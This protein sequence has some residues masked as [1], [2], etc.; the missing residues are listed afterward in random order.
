M[1]VSSIYAAAGLAQAAYA[2][3]LESGDTGTALSTKL[4]VPQMLEKGMTASQADRTSLQYLVIH[5]ETYL[6]SGFSATLFRDVR[7]NEY[8]FALRGSARFSVSEPDWLDANIDN[9][10]NGVSRDQ[11]V[12]MV[13]LYIRLTSSSNAIVSQYRYDFYS[14]SVVVASSASGLGL[15]S[16]S[17]TLTITGHSLGGHLAT[18]FALLFPS[19]AVDAYTFNS[20]GFIGWSRDLFNQL[21]ELLRT[22]VT[23]VSITPVTSPINPI[24]DITAPLD[25][26]SH[27][28]EAHLG[29]PMEV[30]VES[31]DEL[32]IIENHGIDRLVDALAVINFM[33]ELDDRLTIERANQIIESASDTMHDSLDLVMSG[34]A[35]LFGLSG[36]SFDAGNDAVYELIEM[37]SEQLGGAEF[38]IEPLSGTDI[39][40]YAL[41]DTE[42]GRGYRFALVN[43]LPFAITSNL[44]E[45]TANSAEYDLDNFSSD[46]LTDRAMLLSAIAQRNAVDGE[47]PAQILGNA[48]RF[49][50]VEIGEFFAGA[51]SSGQGGSNT[52]DPDD[53]TN[54][55]FGNDEA[56]SIHGLSQD[57]RLY[58]MAGD[59][60]IDGNSGSDL[61]EGGA[62]NDVMQGGIGTDYLF[63]GTGDD[64]YIYADGDGLDFISDTS[65]DNRLQVNGVILSGSLATFT[66]LAPGIDTYVAFDGLGEVI[67]NAPY[68]RKV[69]AGLI[70]H[71]NDGQGGLIVINDWDAVSNNFGITLSENTDSIDVTA[72]LAP[73]GIGVTETS[74]PDPNNT[75]QTLYQLVGGSGSDLIVGNDRRE[76]L[77]G[78]AGPDLLFGGGGTD[79]VS[80]G[81]GDDV[82]YANIQSDLDNIRQA[83]EG[84]IVATRDFLSGGDGDDVLVGSAGIE[85]GLAGGAGNDT[86]Y[87][88]KGVDHIFG[89]HDW[90]AS[91]HAW[92]VTVT[93]VNDNGFEY[94]NFVYSAN[95]ASSSEPPGDDTIYAGDG[96]DRVWAG[97][98]DDVV[99]GGAGAD[100]LTGDAGND[101][102]F[103]G[104]GDDSL[105]GDNFDTRLGTQYGY[106][107]DFLDGGEG[108][109]TLRGN[110]GDDYLV[111]GAG[112]DELYGDM[113]ALAGELHGNDTLYGGAGA[114]NL[115]GQGGRDLLFGGDDDDFLWGDSEQVSGQFHDADILFGGNGHDELVGGGGSDLL[116]GNAGDDLLIGDSSYLDAMYHGAD[117]L[118]GGDGNDQVSGNGGDDKIFGEQG[119]DNLWGNAGNDIIFGGDGDDDLSGNEGD[120]VL[121]GG[122]GSDR[123]FA[124][125]GND[126]LIGDSGDDILYGGT[127]YDQYFVSGFESDLI[128]DEDDNYSV[129]T[130]LNLSDIEHLRVTE[131]ST[132]LS[133]SNGQ[134]LTFSDTLFEDGKLHL[135]TG[136][137]FDR[138]NIEQDITLSA[139]GRTYIAGTQN[140][141]V[142][143]GSGADHIL[144]AEGMDFLYGNGGADTLEGG[145]QDDI[146]WGDTGNDTLL[147]GEGR[148]ILWGGEGDDFLAGGSDIDT[149]VGG[150]GSDTYSVW[151]NEGADVIDNTDTSGGFD[152]LYIHGQL[153]PVAD[154]F[155]RDGDDLLIDTGVDV[156]TVLNQFREYG[157]DNNRFYALDNIYFSSTGTS[158]TA[159]DIANEVGMPQ[160]FGESFSI[161]VGQPWVVTFDELL[162]NDFLGDPGPVTITA[163]GNSYN[164]IA[165]LNP[166]DQTIT[167][168]SAQNLA[169]EAVFDYTV[170]NGISSFSA[171][172]SLQL[173]NAPPEVSSDSLSTML[174]QSRVISFA[175]LLANDR[176]ADG[177]ELDIIAIG[178]V[179]HGQIEFDRPNRFITF[180]PEPGY[181]GT[182][183]F[184]FTVTDGYERVDTSAYVYVSGPNVAPAAAPDQMIIGKNQPY[185][186]S[187]AEL[188]ENDRDANEDVL[189]ITAVSPSAHGSVVLD[190]TEETITFTPSADYVGLATFELTVSDGALHVNS[191]VSID[192]RDSPVLLGTLANDSLRIEP[193]RHLDEY[194]VYGLEGNDDIR[195]YGGDKVIYGGAGDDSIT[196]LQYAP[197]IYGGLGNDV[198][199]GSLGATIYGGSGD[200]IIHS[201][202]HVT[203][204]P[205][206]DI[207]YGDPL[208]ANTYYYNQGD[209]QDRIVE[210]FG[211]GAYYGVNRLVFGAGITMPGSMSSDGTEARFNNVDIVFDGLKPFEFTFELADGS[212]RSAGDISSFVRVERDTPTS[213]GGG[214]G[215]DTVIVNSIC[216]DR[217]SGGAGDDYLVAM[218]GHDTVLGG[219]GNDIIEIIGQYG[220]GHRFYGEGGDDVY[221]LGSGSIA[222]AH[223]ISTYDHT[224]IYQ[225]DAGDDRL[226]INSDLIKPWNLSLSKVG[227]DLNL[228]Y[229]LLSLTI[230]N[231]FL[232]YGEDDNRKLALDRIEFGALEKETSYAEGNPSI[233]WDKIDTAA[234]SPTVVWNQQYIAE[235]VGLTWAG[236]SEVVAVDDFLVA[237]QNSSFVM[238]FSDL[239]A[240]D[241]D[242]DNDS[243]TIESVAN[244]KNGTVS[245]DSV[246]RIITFAP[247][248]D[249]QG[250]ARFEYTVNDGFYTDKGIVFLSV[251]GP[252]APEETF[253]YRGN[254]IRKHEGGGTFSYAAFDSADRQVF[255][256]DA[257]GTVTEVRYDTQNRVTDRIV[258]RTSVSEYLAAWLVDNPSEVAPSASD[259]SAFFAKIH[260]EG[261]L[262]FRQLLANSDANYEMDSEQWSGDNWARVAESGDL[263]FKGVVAIGTIASTAL[264]QTINLSG[265]DTAVIDSA[266]GALELTIGGSHLSPADLQASW[267][268]TFYD[269]NPADG[270]LQLGSPFV[271][272]ST[273]DDEWRTEEFQ[274]GVPVGARYAALV[275]SAT[276]P[277][278]S[279]G[280]PVAVANDRPVYFDDLRVEAHLAGEAGDFVPEADMAAH[281]QFN[282]EVTA[283]DLASLEIETAKL[284]E[285]DFE[286][287]LVTAAD[288][289]PGV[290]VSLDGE[291]IHFFPAENFVGRPG[292]QVSIDDSGVS[293]TAA[294]DVDVQLI[295]G[296]D[297]VQLVD[298]L[299]GTAAADLL[300]GFAGDDT[301]RGHDGDDILVG[302]PG[303]DSLTGGEGSDTYRF[304]RGDGS[305]VI[306]NGAADNLSTTDTL[307]I[308][309]DLSVVT[310]ARTGASLDLILSLAGG[311]ALRLTDYF[312]D[313]AVDLIQFDSGEVWRP[314][315]AKAIVLTG[316]TGNDT[317]Y[318]FAG[319]DVLIGNGGSDVLYGSYLGGNDTLFGGQGDDTLIGCN[320]GENA[321][322]GESG[323]DLLLSFGAGADTLDGGVGNDTLGAGYGGIDTLIGGQGSDTY[324]YAGE[325][326]EKVI[327]NYSS[328]WAA[329]DDVLNFQRESSGEEVWFS[330]AGDDLLVEFVGR[331]G[332]AVLMNWYQA[333][334]SLINPYAYMDEMHAGSE[335]LSIRNAQDIV[336]F[337]VLVQ[338]M[339]DFGDRSTIVGD[340]GVLPV[341]NP[342]L[343]NSLAAAQSSAWD[344]ALT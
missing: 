322:Y 116:Y 194:L 186:F 19:V 62:G 46:Y 33:S 218:G 147:G 224:N 340:G 5:Q 117:T 154:R 173:T 318:D 330:R 30:S 238:T 146:L 209:G 28:G 155:S 184:E 9:A 101:S 128:Y 204:G 149:L 242:L 269:A 40:T 159:V 240:N 231:H 76:Q 308:D 57:D 291:M 157:T 341:D 121:S 261:G 169:A 223:V 222:G 274:I 337:D 207:L 284:V 43:L 201:G 324:V 178:P 35:K 175:E 129:Y 262:H 227:Y 309:A 13:N 60:T 71:L 123:L 59:D 61:L 165:T 326:G 131:T 301:L 210:I 64:T 343:L 137:A 338:A 245:I 141:I 303:S 52:V 106:G 140:D 42:A 321:L 300:F 81:T 80:G 170:S 86:I 2:E 212:V 45:T 107:D 285:S 55:V 319:D 39:A 237:T 202:R 22:S 230:A 198:I 100:H 192:V 113:T 232:H 10:L 103:G 161:S 44:S 241:I 180:T 49:K 297:S 112:D 287:V 305:D 255:S 279:K 110:R 276:V 151:L 182:A 98:G 236:T 258:Y 136:A 213:F 79:L 174:N 199:Q 264:E 104:P 307:I 53:V 153:Q 229:G 91:S 282:Y 316:T 166:T 299:A 239:L 83:T 50:D 63:G 172:V 244:A 188:L 160:V 254:R 190:A 220:A 295:S 56:N 95:T 118:F 304:R 127:G 32:S 228:S 93:T 203:G 215:A 246:A 23:D 125:E 74:F 226:I 187:F 281:T 87:G 270:G 72:P 171:T 250:D 85:E 334:S 133:I 134:I 267:V 195:L 8:V 37:L 208:F 273:A 314:A 325:Y 3:S 289:G 328:S 156:I 193:W 179:Y 7:T 253:D 216:D 144:G 152:T 89:D 25:I 248:V 306:D 252:E 181:T 47:H 29:S 20:P 1:K 342:A 310:A 206:N 217:V 135:A 26:V 58:G 132:F 148:D 214:Q 271:A 167:F 344:V 189:T 108:N 138:R 142:R 65:G 4:T 311:D 66:Q 333:G 339:A 16:V 27:I 293:R 312:G 12:D 145:S 111:G 221:I 336:E 219:H 280:N 115:L 6:E 235:A 288:A 163:V 139:A 97:G 266:D 120:D 298:D 260:Q 17:S 69:S 77:L 259:I 21:G 14:D 109:D 78:Y 15:L 257:E 96:D 164:G 278:P 75:G 70:L 211:G 290:A 268:I 150:Q 54:I 124:D 196:V 191:S 265:F 82:L 31:L 177:H 263:R 233:F 247:D 272:F 99:Y 302:G 323:N 294:I 158:W 51:N 119:N 225:E 94:D 317:I 168:V 205:G 92:T 197:T 102:L 183:R 243:L 38:D 315:L 277:T 256:I 332:S 176:D 143:G 320:S 68:V 286:T 200:D 105:W 275:V 41:A 234:F 249:F 335:M 292:F 327:D 73:S 162:A 185:V 11:V 48:I 67:P 84:N 283:N 331:E 122:N 88:G 130:Q 126:I 36:P 296:T 114:D 251:A 24:T 18:A 90:I 313:S 329:D 34:F